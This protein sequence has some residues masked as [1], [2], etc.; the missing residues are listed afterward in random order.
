MR[1]RKFLS[2]RQKFIYFF[3]AQPHWKTNFHFMARF[4]SHPMHLNLSFRISTTSSCLMRNLSSLTD[5]SSR[6]MMAA[7]RNSTRIFNRPSCTHQIYWFSQYIFPLYRCCHDHGLIYI[8]VKKK[9]VFQT[10][11]TWLYVCVCVYVIKK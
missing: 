6:R 8:Y 3:N 9:Q 1:E 10:S 7:A 4:S 2:Y 5:R 11:L